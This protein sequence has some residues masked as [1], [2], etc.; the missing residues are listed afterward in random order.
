MG[1]LC[2]KSREDQTKNEEKLMFL[3]SKFY[4]NDNTGGMALFFYQNYFPVLCHRF[5][6]Y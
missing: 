3:T 4:K 6:D 5:I 1:H 2:A